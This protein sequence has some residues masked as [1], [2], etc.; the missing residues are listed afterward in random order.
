MPLKQPEVMI[1][2]PPRN[3]FWLSLRCADV[4]NKIERIP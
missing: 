4:T 1:N 2:D 3:E